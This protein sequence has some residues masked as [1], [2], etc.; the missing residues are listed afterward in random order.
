MLLLL[1]CVG[2][3]DIEG[4]DGF[5]LVG[6]AWRHE[7]MVTDRAL[8]IGEGSVEDVGAAYFD[9]AVRA[10]TYGNGCDIEREYLA[11]WGELSAEL[12]SAYDEGDTCDAVGVFLEQ[13]ES[14]EDGLF[15]DGWK[16]ISVG[17]CGSEVGADGCRFELG[18]FPIADDNE[19][20]GIWATYTEY[21][22]ERLASRW[23]ADACALSEADRQGRWVVVEGKF[24]VYALDDGAPLDGA[25]EGL[26]V[27][28]GDWE[29]NGEEAR[30]VGDI[31][32]TFSAEWC[33]LEAPEVIALVY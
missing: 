17:F 30:S 32:A 15:G 4:L 18:D 29:A 20:Y 19:W 27:E 33:D 2:S 22:V 1:A 16:E 12:A 26:L 25:V 13:L 9:A 28:R 8:L 5:G 3:V 10:A 21:P 23:D 14:V 7:G 11:R 24:S 31:D 6:S